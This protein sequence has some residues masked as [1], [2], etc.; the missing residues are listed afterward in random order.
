[1]TQT[2]SVIPLAREMVIEDDDPTCDFMGA[3]QLKMQL[4]RVL[5]VPDG[6]K[7]TV[8]EVF[9]WQKHVNR[10]ISIPMSDENFAEC[11]EWLAMN[12]KVSSAVRIQITMTVDGKEIVVRFPVWL[13]R[14]LLGKE[15]GDA[16]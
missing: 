2:P 6:Y 7:L 1:M 12:G 14:T 10:P 16:T 13:V 5:T 9:E 4:V 8:G 3:S 15:T 11:W